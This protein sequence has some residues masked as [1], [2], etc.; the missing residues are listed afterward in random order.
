MHYFLFQFILFTSNTLISVTVTSRNHVY[1]TF[2]IH[3]YVRN[4]TMQYF[5][6]SPGTYCI[7]SADKNEYCYEQIGIPS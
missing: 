5:F 6:L 2:L 3:N 4:W 7:G 1:E